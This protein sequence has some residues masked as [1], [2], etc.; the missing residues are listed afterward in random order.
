MSD[1]LRSWLPDEGGEFY[2]L[3][4]TPRPLPPAVPRRRLPRWL[5]RLVYAVRFRVSYGE[6]PITWHDE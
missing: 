3:D 1:G 4:R 2:G 5:D 6:W